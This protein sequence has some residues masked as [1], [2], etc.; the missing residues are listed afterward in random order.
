MEQLDALDPR[1]G[2]V[3][4]GDGGDQRQERLDQLRPGGSVACLRGGDQFPPQRLWQAGATIEIAQVA[5]GDRRH[6][7]LGLIQLLG[8]RPIQHSLAAGVQLD[9]L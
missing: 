4:A 3:L 9:R 5:G 2:A 8:Q 7:G 1:R 6:V